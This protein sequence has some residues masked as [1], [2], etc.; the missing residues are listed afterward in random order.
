[1]NSLELILLYLLAAVLGVVLF[2]VLRLPTMLGYLAV[3]AIIGP[4]MLSLVQRSASLTHLAEF[5]VV[6]LMFV[7]GLEFSLPK[8]R[9]MRRHVFGLGALQVGL[10]MAVG[11]LIMLGLR[12]WMP[13]VWRVSWPGAVALAGVLAMS[14]TAIV[15]KLMAERMELDSEHGKRVVGVLLFQDLAVVPL[16]ILI[17][18]LGAHDD[19]LGIELL[20]GLVKAGVVVGLL[21]TAGQ[22]ITKWWLHLVAQTRSEEL[23]MLNILLL[24]LGLAWVTEMAG[25]SLALGAF[26]AGMLVAETPY[27][28]QVEADIQPFYDLLLGLF[29]I[30][31]GMM[32]DWREVVVHWNWMLFL[33]TVP[34]LFKLA[35]VWVSAYGLGASNG[36]ALRTG[37]YLAQAGEF[38]FVLLNLAMKDKLLPAP[39]FNAILASM[40][41]SMM[42]T[43][44]I[45]M[46]S[47][48]I[49]LRLARDEWML[50]SQ[51]VT[52]IARKAMG[53]QGHVLICGFGRTGQA[54]ARLLAQEKMAYIA[55][56]MDPNLVRQAS[57]AGDRVVYGDGTREQ[58]LHAAGVLR[59]KLVVI[60]LMDIPRTLQ[61]LGL[62]RRIAPQLPVVVRTQDDKHLQTLRDAGATE[63]VPEAVEGSMLLGGHALALAGVPMQR[64]EQMINEQRA[65]RYRLL[66][67]YFHNASDNEEDRD[68][69]D[70]LQTVTLAER[71]QVL[72]KKLVQ[73]YALLARFQVRVMAVRAANGSALELEDD[74]RM[75]LGMT[76]VLAGNQRDLSEAEDFLSQ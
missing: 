1:M 74:L 63:V 60:T 45:I 10:T 19:D 17:P 22:K 57:A 9:T 18:A 68:S 6:F 43:P 48:R 4:H 13:P 64:I 15:I 44:F 66:R 55:L 8:L 26:L 3:G 31:V 53:Q 2:R 65:Q 42:A 16:L 49:V 21:L 47:K 52:Q 54:V 29:F 23:F 20:L 14:S 76:L 51:Q 30:T 39:L 72:D 75:Q 12:N 28:Y 7:I 70:F 5:G 34:V 46:A 35:V 50:E 33:V 56:D 62:L 40:V 38:G 69:D 41:L 32:L 27:K 73:V 58:T 25:L 37:L 67:D 36:V 11:T 71:T 61:V 24:T 59:A